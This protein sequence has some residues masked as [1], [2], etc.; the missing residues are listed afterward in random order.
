MRCVI[1]MYAGVGEGG[2]QM[3]D[4]ARVP[5]EED[6]ELGGFCC[7]SILSETLMVNNWVPVL[8]HLSLVF[9][10]ARLYFHE[11]LNLDV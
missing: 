10:M 9:I 4:T 1:A 5:L 8:N 11:F 2:A 3:E 7:C 6:G